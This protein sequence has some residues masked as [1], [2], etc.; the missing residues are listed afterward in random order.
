MHKRNKKGKVGNAKDINIVMPMYN[1]IEYSDDY[2]KTWDFM[3]I[4][5]RS[6]ILNNVAATIDFTGNNHSSKSF[7]YKQKITGQTGDNGEIK[8][9]Y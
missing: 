9:F 5:Q 6:I 8:W 3:T 2:L 7:K 4:L 1:L